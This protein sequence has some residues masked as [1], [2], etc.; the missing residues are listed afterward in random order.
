M[1]RKG[2]FLSAIIL[3]LFVSLLAFFTAGCGAGVSRS[4]SGPSQLSQ[5][6]AGEDAK[7]GAKTL[8]RVHFLDVGQADCILIQVPGGKNVLIDGGNNDDGPAV[9]SYLKKQGVRRLDV[10]VATHPHEDHVGGLDS[11]L[12]AFEAGKVYA[13]RVTANTKSFEDFLLAVQRKGLKIT[14]ARAGMALDLGPAASAL[15]LAPAGTGYED[16]NDYSAVLKLTCGGTSFLFTGDAEAV[17]EAEMLRSGRD[18]KADV[19]KVGHH[20]SASSTTAEFLKAVSPKYAV[21]S[22]GAGNDYHHPSPK[23]L[24]RLAAAGVKIFRTD[25]RGT[26]VVESDGQQITVQD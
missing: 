19:L 11:V 23:T 16:L 5:E 18:L 25:E 17:S 10:V 20:G 4:V 8:L 15:F 7:A 3:L 9:V 13:P 6:T 1:S 26:V 14:E 2:A 21:I 12:N 24:A 22:V